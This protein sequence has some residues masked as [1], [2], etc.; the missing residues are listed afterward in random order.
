[1][2]NSGSYNNCAYQLENIDRIVSYYTSLFEYDYFKNDNICSEFLFLI[3]NNAREKLS[4]KLDEF[5]LSEDFR[6]FD[7]EEFG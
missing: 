1:M 5:N 6:F 4:N 3:C 2:N 7:V